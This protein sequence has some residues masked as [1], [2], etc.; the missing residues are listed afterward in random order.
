MGTVQIIH[1]NSEIKL[2]LL[3]WL[4]WQKENELQY[5]CGNEALTTSSLSE[6]ISN[7]WLLSS[8]KIFRCAETWKM[9]NYS[10]DWRAY[11]Y[12]NNWLKLWNQINFTGLVKMAKRKRAAIF[13]WEWGVDHIKLVGANF[14]FMTLIVIE[15]FSMCW[16]LKNGEFIGR[17]MCIKKSRISLISNSLNFE[18][19]RHF[20]V[21]KIHIKSKYR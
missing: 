1:W 12:S 19:L 13:M 7:L 15:D 10:L 20:F 8:S 9:A 6:R 5:L 14:Q 18:S 3:G 21:I 17:F 4:R 11:L 16:E 2:T